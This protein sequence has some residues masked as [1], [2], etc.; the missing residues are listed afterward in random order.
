MTDTGTVRTERRGAV[1]W[2]I[3][4]RPAAR[5]AL[6]LTMRARALELLAEAEADDDVAAIALTGA[7]GHF[8]GGGDIASMPGV[9]DVWD[10]RARTATAQ[11][12]VGALR[13]AEKPTIAVAQGSVVGLGVSLFAVCDLRLAATDAR[14]QAGF[15]GVGLIPDGGLLH[16]LP[17]LIGMGRARDWLMLDH[18]ID[19]AQAHAWGLASRTAD[20]EELDALAAELAERMSRLSRNALAMTKA[21]LRLAADASWEAVLEFERTAQGALLDDPDARARV[22]AFLAG[23]RG[24]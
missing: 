16:L 8:C 4:D 24:G 17:P 18:P 3:L 23:R 13:Q 20:G 11:A 9:R 2:L 22:E 14:L 7:A 10:G 12:L 15:P 19:G 1:A 6:T 21:G 5:N